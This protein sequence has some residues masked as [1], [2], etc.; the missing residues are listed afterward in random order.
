MK[1]MTTGRTTISLS[2]VI[3]IPLAILAF[4]A[5]VLFSRLIAPPGP[6]THQVHAAA[7]RVA[8]FTNDFVAPAS[9]GRATTEIHQAIATVNSTATFKLRVRYGVKN[10]GSYD[11]QLYTAHDTECVG[12]DF[13][14]TNQIWT[15]TPGNCQLQAGTP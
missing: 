6:T 10:Y 13:S 8:A 7:N 3:V 15:A 9:L 11:F 12:Y 4:V 14:L 5:I 1:V 2:R